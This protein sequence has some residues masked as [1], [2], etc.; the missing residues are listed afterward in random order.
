MCR[1]TRDSEVVQIFIALYS[2]EDACDVAESFS[3]NI[4]ITIYCSYPLRIMIALHVFF[5]FLDAV[6]FS[7]GVGFG[8]SDNALLMLSVCYNLKR[9]SPWRTNS[10]YLP[11]PFL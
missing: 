5:A 8:H 7:H 1:I 9:L 6:V 10:F 4:I 2:L 11:G 3:M